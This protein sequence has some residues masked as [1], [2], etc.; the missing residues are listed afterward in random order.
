MFMGSIF[1]VNIP[2][3]CMVCGIFTYLWLTYPLVNQ[4]IAI[5]GISPLFNDGS[6]H[7][8]NPGLF[9]QKWNLFNWAVLSDEQMSNECPFSLLN[10]EQMSNW[11]GVEHQPVKV[12][13]ALFF[14]SGDGVS[15][16]AISQE[17]PFFVGE[18]GDFPP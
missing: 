15:F 5:A 17:V 16:F 18:T 8:L 12:M 4:Q 14:H 9:D 13:G 3:T 11:L 6:I 2:V 7:R 1:W 10:D